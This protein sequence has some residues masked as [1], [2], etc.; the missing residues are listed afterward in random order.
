MRRGYAVLV[1]R[2]GGCA[3]SHRSTAAWIFRGCSHDVAG[4]PLH[5]RHTRELMRR[6]TDPLR[7]TPC[8]QLG[9]QCPACGSFSARRGIPRRSHGFFGAATSVRES[10]PRDGG[11]A[12]QR[13]QLVR[14]RDTADAA[15]DP[16]VG[17]L[18]GHRRRLTAPS[19]PG[20]AILVG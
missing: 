17:R 7:A 15:G 3:A 12:E 4:S 13:A 11:V 18:D 14:A 10:V 16:P 1:S 5:R 9:P 20:T 8:P 2:I 19:A 6:S